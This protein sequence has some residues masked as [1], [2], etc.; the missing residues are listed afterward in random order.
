MRLK[1]ED[2]TVFL[3]AIKESLNHLYA[4]N[5]LRKRGYCF[6]F[7]NKSNIKLFKKQ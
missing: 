4:K 2:K 6:F 1:R 7:I 3:K 5:P